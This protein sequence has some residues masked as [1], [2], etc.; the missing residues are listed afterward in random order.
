MKTK[1]LKWSIDASS[2][3]KPDTQILRKCKKYTQK[4]PER[5]KKERQTCQAERNNINGLPRPSK[6]LNTFIS[7]HEKS[8]VDIL[9]NL[10]VY[11]SLLCELRAKRILLISDVL[12]KGI[13]SS[14]V[15]NRPFISVTLIIMLNIFFYLFLVVVLL[16]LMRLFY[17]RYH[18]RRIQT[19]IQ[20]Q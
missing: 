7:S 12:I 2:H 8:R 5:P 13:S 19:R 9:D 6:C 1:Y 10:N 16:F 15:N 14:N 20:Q 11:Y 17:L 4:D 18:L 3:D